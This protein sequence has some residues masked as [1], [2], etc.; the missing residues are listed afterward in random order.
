MRAFRFIL[1]VLILTLTTVSQSWAY[2]Q[3]SILKVD[4][5]LENTSKLLPCVKALL[6]EIPLPSGSHLGK[7]SQGTLTVEGE[8]E[9]RIFFNV[10]LKTTTGKIGD[11]PIYLRFVKVEQ[12][13]IE[14][15]LEYAKSGDKIYIEQYI[16]NASQRK[17][18]APSSLTVT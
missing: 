14:K 9:G 7:D 11:P 4:D 5:N 12:I 8:K 13:D 2:S 3:N 10:I 6:N 15:V 18:C 17:I 1:M 16:T